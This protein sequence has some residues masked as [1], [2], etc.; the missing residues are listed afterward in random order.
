VTVIV[1]KFGILSSTNWMIIYKFH[2]L[3]RSFVQL[4]SVYRRLWPTN[5]GVFSDH[6]G[7]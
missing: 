4:R 5:S 2:S 7:I 3:I 1:F 6:G